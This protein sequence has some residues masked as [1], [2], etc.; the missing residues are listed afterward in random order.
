MHICLLRR[1]SESNYPKRNRIK[2]KQLTSISHWTE[3]TF[4]HT[5]DGIC[6]LVIASNWFSPAGKLA[7][8]LQEVIQ[9]LADYTGCC[10]DLLQQLSIICGSL[11]G[12][13][14]ILHWTIHQFPSLN[15]LFLAHRG[16]NGGTHNLC[17]KKTQVL[18]KGLV[19]RKL[20]SN[21]WYIHLLGAQD[22]LF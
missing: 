18:R 16:A 19:G 9:S 11:T 12:S 6:C 1:T 20:P 21:Q 17:C 14:T 4:S 13:D 2:V 22:S 10:A 15:Q 8:M 7:D 3:D 5:H